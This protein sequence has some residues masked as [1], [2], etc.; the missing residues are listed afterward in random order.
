MP[1]VRRLVALILATAIITTGF[2]VANPPAFA[3]DPPN[4]GAGAG[5]AKAGNQKKPARRKARGNGA[6][7][8]IVPYPMPPVLIIRHAGNPR[9]D[10]GFPE[11]A[12]LLLISRDRENKRRPSRLPRRP[13]RFSGST[14]APRLLRLRAGE[15]YGRR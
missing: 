14:L 15:F 12:P 2:V 4:Q 6:V 8:A 10:P 7:G 5:K 11:Y 3:Q 9:R 13:C 1:L